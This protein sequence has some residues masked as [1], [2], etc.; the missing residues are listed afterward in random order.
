[1]KVLVNPAKS[2]DVVAVVGTRLNPMNV[3]FLGPPGSGK[4][5]QAKRLATS[6]GMFHFSTGDAFREAIAKQTTVGKKIK[7]FVDGGQLVPD[8]VVSE[9]VFEKLKA[10][11]PK[12]GVLLDGYPRTLQQAKSLDE[13]SV[14]E[15]F[16]IGSVIFFDVNAED[17]I[18]RLSARR[19]CPKCQ[20]VFNLVT[21]PPRV[22]GRC[23]L[24][25]TELVQR[26]DDRAEVVKERLAVYDRQTAPLLA[27]YEGKKGFHRINA[28]QEIDRVY[29]Q[30]M[31]IFRENP[32]SSR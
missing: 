29:A 16:Q 7:G 3:I 6:Q 17:L 4:G 21:R 30:I 12:A 8:D 27:Y 25:S 22:E 31:G 13:F 10:G 1:M 18:R 26:P 11:V 24:C 32:S 2:Q 19:Q 5:T 9:L 14:S 20:E 23:D 15:R 28:A